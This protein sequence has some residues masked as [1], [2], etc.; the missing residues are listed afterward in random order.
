MVSLRSK[1]GA[2]E[3]IFDNVIYTLNE[4]DLGTADAELSTFKGVNQVGEYLNHTTIGTRSISIVGYV[5][6]DSQEEMRVRKRDLIK[7]VNPLDT[8]DLVVDGYRLSCVASDTVRFA[9]ARYENNNKLCKFMLSA[10]AVNPCFVPLD[11]TTIKVALWR[12]VF[13]FPLVLQANE[14]FIVGVREPSKIANIQNSGD[15]E[16]GMLVEFVAKGE[17]SNPYLLNLNTR[18]QIKINKTLS[19]GEVIRV[20]TNYGKKTVLGTIDG[21][22]TN[23]FSF[24]DL[25]STFIQ[26]EV[27]E[28]EFRWG[29]DSNE[30][31][32]EVNIMFSPKYLG[33]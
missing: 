12:A 30:S 28:N 32:L 21:E 11:E 19:K 23:Y 22:E 3:I 17:V 15:I 31:N 8:F 6:A 24:L 2:K 25:N 33:V 14:P 20:N 18:E 29:A 26:L 9:V 13:K 16:T 5:F 10:E 7:L 27:G 4:M 1:D